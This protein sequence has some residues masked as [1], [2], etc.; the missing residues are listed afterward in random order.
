MR[1]MSV[2]AL[3]IGAAG[4]LLAAGAGV[5]A[6]QALAA[7]TA[8]P[9]CQA[10][11]LYVSQGTADAGAGQLYVPVVFTNTSTRTC[12]LRGYPGVSL[13]NAAHKALAPAATRQK[14][15]VGTVDLKPAGKASALLHLV[16]GP[17]GGACHAASTYVQ[18]YAPASTKAQFLPASLKYCPPTF[19]VGTVHAGTKG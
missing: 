3:T 5:G 12:A 1:T 8:V 15:T 18:I 2:R 6:S 4:V 7:S 10:G 16:N 19:T 17:I 9:T 14:E 11:D 13:V